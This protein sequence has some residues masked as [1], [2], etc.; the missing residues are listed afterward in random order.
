MKQKQTTRRKYLQAMGAVA[1]FGDENGDEGS[2]WEKYFGDEDDESGEY[3][4]LLGTKEEFNNTEAKK[5]TAFKVVPDGP[6]YRAVDDPDSLISGKSKWKK[7]PSTGANPTFESAKIG[8]LR[9]KSSGNSYDV[10]SLAGGGIDPTAVSVST[11]TGWDTYDPADYADLFSAVNQVLADI[12]D[13]EQVTIYLPVTGSS[14]VSVSTTLSIPSADVTPNIY[15]WGYNATVINYTATDGTPAIDHASPPNDEDYEWAQ[16]ALIGPGSGAGGGGNGIQIGADSTTST[17]HSQT[18]RKLKVF[19]FPGR[20]MEIYGF[21]TGSISHCNV[22][23]NGGDG[24]F[25]RRFNG[26]NIENCMLQVNGGDQIR[27][28]DCINGVIGPGNDFDAAGG[29]STPAGS[30]GIRVSNPSKRGG[31]NI[32][33]NYFEQTETHV[34]LETPTNGVPVRGVS[35]RGNRFQNGTT[36]VHVANNVNRSYVV[37]NWF[38]G[39]GSQDILLDGTG[40]T[41]GPNTHISSTAKVTDNTGSTSEPESYAMNSGGYPW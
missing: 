7:I 15:G 21:F 20:G 9:D 10:D 13:G 38:Q 26:G 41:L 11:E 40:S 3:S 16:F 1:V 25:L 22:Q 30:V 8:T 24:I 29:G 39:V 31:P 33:D 12:T 18:L 34:L 35:I 28:E 36:G 4:L 5:N 2:L 6:V 23:D 17:N 32:V 19:S 14:G 27:A 37:E